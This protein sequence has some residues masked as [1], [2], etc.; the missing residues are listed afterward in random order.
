MLAKCG[1]AEL[2]ARL[3]KPYEVK[4]FSEIGTTSEAPGE[5]SVHKITK[6]ET[7]VTISGK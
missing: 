1:E 4:V 3:L 6:D 5:A 7:A 2:N